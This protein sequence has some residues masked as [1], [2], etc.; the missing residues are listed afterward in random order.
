M[1][2]YAADKDEEKEERNIEMMMNSRNN[3]ESEIRQNIILF[4]DNNKTMRE[5]WLH[6]FKC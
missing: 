4:I 5:R 3:Y 1:V 6:F 2:I